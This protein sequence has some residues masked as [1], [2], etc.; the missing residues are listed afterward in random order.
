MQLRPYQ[1]EDVKFI[2]EHPE[3]GVFSEQRV[4]KTPTVISAI[5]QLQLQKIIVICP[6]SIVYSWAYEFEKWSNIPTII[7]DKTTYMI[8]N[9]F[10]GAVIINY[11][12]FRKR[13]TL[14]D[15][16]VAWNP[17]CVIVDEA[18]RMKDRKSQ[19]ATAIARFKK[20][21]RKIALTGTPCTNKP[22]DVW[23]ILNWL[24]PR[25]YT[26]YWN[27]VNEYFIQQPIYFGGRVAHQPI[28]FRPHKQLYL[29]AQLSTF[30]VQ[31][32]RREVMEW[33]DE[34]EPEDIPLK[35]SVSEVSIINDLE[36][37]FEH[38]H[39][40]TKS[41]IDTMIRIRQIC[42]DV[43]I[44]DLKGKSTKTEWLKGYLADYAEENIIIFSNSKLYL[45]ILK[46]DLKLPLI[47]GDTPKEERKE[48]IEEF[49]ENG[50]VLLAQTQ[51]CKEGLTLD[52]ADTTIFLDIFP[53]SADYLQAKDRMVATTED[54][55]K[56]KKLLRVYLENTLDEK[57]VHAVDNNISATSFINDYSIYLERR[58]NE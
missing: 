35:P 27:F 46:N 45:K 24:K 53:P 37:W 30:C 6:A 56:P 19:T 48:I 54:R 12:K 32:K 28:A 11:E 49:Q 15:S 22:W 5:A 34:I 55:V 36:T 40:V 42:D 3:C 39:I 23:T 1:I 21:P 13:N 44:L 17:E 29:Q 51:A 52:N 10:K 57:C 26:S 43:R 50:G 9:D 41:T 20:V 4:G 16:A 38:K 14:Q 8:P 47:C 18:H 33:L 58:Y 25:V 2:I 7:P 31:R